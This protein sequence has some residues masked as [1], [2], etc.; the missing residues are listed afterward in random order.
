MSIATFVQERDAWARHEQMRI[1][2]ARHVYEQQCK[3][4]TLQQKVRFMYRY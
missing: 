4:Y 1:E 2:S 3:D